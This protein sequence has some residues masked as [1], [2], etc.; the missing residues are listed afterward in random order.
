MIEDGGRMIEDGAQKVRWNGVTTLKENGAPM[1]QEDEL[2]E[3]LDDL[4]VSEC[5]ANKN[6]ET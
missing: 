6:E 1:V 4:V 3:I 2:P 5:S